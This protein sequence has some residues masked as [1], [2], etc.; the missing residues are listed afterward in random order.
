MELKKIMGQVGSIKTKGTCIGG[1]LWPSCCKHYKSKTIPNIV[2]NVYVKHMHVSKLNCKFLLLVFFL[3]AWIFLVHAN[4]SISW[5][6]VSV[7]I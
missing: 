4:L 7:N 1:L 5:I 6:C 2:Y 3:S